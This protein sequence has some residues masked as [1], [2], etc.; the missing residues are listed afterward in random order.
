MWMMGPNSDYQ[1]FTIEK[2]RTTWNNLI[3]EGWTQTI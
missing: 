1:K 3:S 2:A